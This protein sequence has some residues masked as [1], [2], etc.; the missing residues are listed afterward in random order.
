MKGSTSIKSIHSIK[1]MQS[2]KK[3]AQENSENPDFLKL[4][5]LEKERTRLRNEKK[6]L[7]LRLEP[8]EARLKEIQEYYAD[9]LGTKTNTGSDKFQSTEQED[10]KTEWETVGINY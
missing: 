6:R 3:D 4:Y 5:I 10:E 9:S 2:I 7:Q 1:S 8:I